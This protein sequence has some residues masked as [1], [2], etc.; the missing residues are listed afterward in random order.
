MIQWNKN[1]IIDTINVN[2]VLGGEQRPNSSIIK[3]Y[4][5]KAVDEIES[6]ESSTLCATVDAILDTL[7]VPSNGI[8]EDPGA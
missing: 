8:T 6:N 4:L 3:K 7:D 1:E 2:T 5:S